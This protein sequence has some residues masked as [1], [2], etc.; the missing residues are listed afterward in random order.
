M[1]LQFFAGYDKYL[2]L[3]ILA[4]MNCDSYFSISICF[5]KSPFSRFDMWLGFAGVKFLRKQFTKNERFI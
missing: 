3:Y 4:I 1:K 2:C 5:I